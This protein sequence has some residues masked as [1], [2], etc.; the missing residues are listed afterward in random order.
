VEH[1]VCDNTGKK[2]SHRNRHKNY[3][4]DLGSHTMKALNRYTTKD[5]YTR[6]VIHNVESA[7]V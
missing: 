2:W 6:N 7:A 1:E 5:S 4:E 3:K